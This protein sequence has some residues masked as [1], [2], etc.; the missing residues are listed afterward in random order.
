MIV[1]NLKNLMKE[2]KITM[3]QLEDMTGM[4]PSTINKARQ[5]EG[6]AECRLST[7]ARIA[8]ALGVPV[9]K[10]FEGEWKNNE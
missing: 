9:K 4:S 8:A 10:V 6:I 2:K 7:L 5:D 1:S 3:K